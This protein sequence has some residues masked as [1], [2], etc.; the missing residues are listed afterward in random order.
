MDLKGRIETRFCVILLDAVLN[1][2]KHAVLRLSEY[3]PIAECSADDACK[4]VRW[5]VVFLKDDLHGKKTAEC[6]NGG[7]RYADV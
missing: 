4:R 2:L 6:C 5:L 7:L 3:T 1:L